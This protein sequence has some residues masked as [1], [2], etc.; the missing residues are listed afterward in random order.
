MA[1]IAVR[2][3]A[4]DSNLNRDD[5]RVKRG[6]ETLTAVYA[7]FF[8]AIEFDIPLVELDEYVRRVASLSTANSEDERA[9]YADMKDVLGE[10]VP[11]LAV[12]AK[13][14]ALLG[15]VRRAV[16][17]EPSYLRAVHDARRLI[18]YINLNLLDVPEQIV[19]PLSRSKKYEIKRTLTPMPVII[20]AICLTV[21][22][23]K[24]WRKFLERLRSGNLPD[25]RKEV[26]EIY[27]RS[28][29]ERA[30]MLGFRN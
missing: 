20:T 11:W 12:H 22:K 17:N 15:S 10:V 25:W 30:G 23:K 1:S 6:L 27:A 19:G 28:V 8:G 24:E 14:N 4:R 13:S 29:T 18:D 2:K 9:V 3:Y 21:A 5:V 26:A 16:V 7:V